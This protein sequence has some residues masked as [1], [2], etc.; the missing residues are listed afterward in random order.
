[1]KYIFTLAFILFE[2]LAF[3][4]AGNENI[5]YSTGNF[6]MRANRPTTKEY[7]IDG[8]PYINGKDFQQVIIQGYSSKIQ[9]LRYNGYEDEMEFEDGGQTYYANKEDGLKIEFKDLKKTYQ[10]LNYS[11][12]SKTRFGYLVLLLENPK[13]SFY[14]REKIEL[15]KGEK[16]PNAYS[17]DANDYY[18]KEKDL[19]LVKK[20]YEFFK[21][22]KNSKEFI[23]RFRADKGEF[24]K[25][26]KI[27]KLSFSKEDDMIKMIGFLDQ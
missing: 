3:A 26:L 13:Y 2:S 12:D 20:G 9:N 16:S 8:N 10:I 4:Q 18:A 17:K 15:L 14:K 23:A 11:F 21:F 6:F 7:I 22:P 25:F 27:N 5:S 24:E 1:M 19:Y